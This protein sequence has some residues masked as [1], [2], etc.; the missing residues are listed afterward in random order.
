MKDNGQEMTPFF[1]TENEITASWEAIYLDQPSQLTYEAVESTSMLV[2]D[3]VK[4]RKL[5]YS[6]RNIQRAYMEMMEVILTN[7]LIQAQSFRNE[8][9]EDRYLHL[10]QENPEL[11]PRISQKLMASFLG[12][13]P[14][15]FSRMK[16][17]M[18]R[19]L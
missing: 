1:W 9:P 8:K 7:T 17:R 10:I 11:I 12:I 3:Y 6:N 16:K 13:T 15:S 2:T 5:V 14:I 4:F 19:E 18:G